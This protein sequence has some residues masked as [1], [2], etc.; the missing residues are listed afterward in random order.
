MTITKK[1]TKRGIKY[2]AQV[3]VDGQRPSKTFH[4]H[5]DAVRWEEETAERLRSGLAPVGEV[6]PGDMIFQ[7]AA[8]RF[9]V[10]VRSNRSIGSLNGYYAAQ[11][12][13]G[14]SFGADVLMSIISP[15][16]VSG[17]ILRRMS[18]DGVGPS[19]VRQELSFLRMVFL[20]APEW[21]V[22]IISPELNI[23]RPS[24]KKVSREES[25]DR[26]IKSEELVAL[27]KEARNRPNNFYYFIAFLLYTGMRPSE[28][29]SLY[30]KRLPV[31][32]ERQAIKDKKHVGF[33]DIKRGGFTKVGTKTEKR[34]VPCHPEALKILSHLKS[35]TPK[36]QL[37][38]FLP[39]SYINKDRSYRVYRRAMKTTL[40]KTQLTD[41]ELIRN[42]I[43]FYSFRHTCRSAMESCGMQMAMGETIIGHNTSSFKFTYIHISD[44]DLIDEMEKLK[45]PGL[46]LE[47]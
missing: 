23:K 35:Q 44:E 7:K 8:D 34:F 41:T 16:D 22:D 13:F 43:D 5:L 4:R 25:L 24:V 26:V 38:V 30:W 33:V 14:E 40:S 12:Q 42:E 46:K 1:K 47:Y 10:E 6:A 20:K 29:S 32:D 39:N 31:K 9:I 15:Q 17:H 36:D 2:L 28:A 11:K 19:C 18:E 3:C 27:F 45:Y 21:G 37:L